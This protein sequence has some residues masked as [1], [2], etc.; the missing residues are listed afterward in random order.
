[1][2]SIFLRR[3]QKFLLPI[4]VAVLVGLSGSLVYVFAAVPP[5]IGSIAFVSLSI[6]FLLAIILN[7]FRNTQQSL[8]ISLAVSFLMFLR[9]VN[10]LSVINLG[11]FAAFLV[12]L[13]L[14]LY[15]K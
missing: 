5:G 12:L 1:M 8:L 9:A 2:F 13:G 10:L 11:L 6:F 7:F 14:Y 3:I 15:K 4:K